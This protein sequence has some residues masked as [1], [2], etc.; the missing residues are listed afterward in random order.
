MHKSIESEVLYLDHN[1]TTPC[2]PRVLEAM[3][4][5]FSDHFWNPGSAHVLG[6]RA[7]RASEDARELAAKSLGVSSDC[8]VFTSGATESIQLALFG[9]PVELLRHAGICVSPIEHRAVNNAVARLENQGL[10]VSRLTLLA[11]GSVDLNSINCPAVYI[12]QAANSETGII[13]AIPSIYTEVQR[14]GGLLVVDASQSLWKQDVGPLIDSSD[15]LIL[16]GHKAYGPKGVGLLIVSD[17]YRKLLR[18][19][20]LEAQEQGI[21]EGTLNVPL[22]IGF[23]SAVEI[24]IREGEAWRKRVLTARDHLESTLISK[25]SGSIEPLLVECERLPNTS[26]L[27]FP[28]V[29]ADVFAAQATQLALS[30]GTACSSGAPTPSSVLLALGMTSQHASETLRLS[31][32][33]DHDVSAANRAI[34]LMCETLSR[35]TGN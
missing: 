32:G 23:A 29:A 33:R 7:R 22:I 13:Q 21:R 4:P 10:R 19:S 18:S 34:D 11:N 30:Y 1:A 28:G 31:F 27:R 12:V 6:R 15:A 24:C 16:S 9:L 3:L 17:A 14:V 8:L 25:Y 26:S 2:D 5:Y 20:R 35:I